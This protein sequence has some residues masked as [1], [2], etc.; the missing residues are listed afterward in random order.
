MGARNKVVW[1]NGL[2]VKPQHFQ[3]QTRYFEH[4]L[5]RLVAGNEPHFYG[6]SSLA[7]NEDLLWLGKI[8]LR[9]ASGVMPDGTVF[10]FP[11]DD[12][13]PEVLDISDGFTANELVYLC[14]PLTI[15][16][17]LEVQPA[18]E[19]PSRASAR[20]EVAEHL[21]R[22]NSVQAGE[23]AALKVARMR[24][25]LALG[26]RD[27]SAY[28]KI[29]VAR[30]VEKDDKGTIR[31]DDRFVPTMLSL[32]AAPHLRRILSDLADGVEGR[33]RSIAGRIGKPDQSG[34]AAVSDFLLL[35][36][37]NRIGALLR[38]YA[39]Q[40]TLHPRG[41]FELLIQMIGELSTFMTEERLCPEL[42]AYNHDRPDLCW[43]VVVDLLRR[44][45]TQTLDSSADWIPLEPKKHGYVL[46][47][48]ADRD[49]IR[50]AEFVLA[51]KASVPQERLQREFTAQAKVASIATI[52]ELVA[53]Q[54]P[55]IPLRLMPVAP[56]QLP[57]HAGYS[58]FALDRST[59]AWRQMADATGFAFHVAGEFPALEMQFW[60]I[61]G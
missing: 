58:Y 2:F 22:D 37:M 15:E 21:A 57:Y 46:A 40:T 13:A 32:S 19:G 31:L 41:V 45:I 9:Q 36:V 5:T 17:G 60:A 25:V 35:Q 51:V 52:R 27:L 38:H 6:F 18:A 14:L 3:Q 56:R 39:R 43:P 54:L 47:P 7:L 20:Y 33:A 30:I 55:G 1:S 29:A 48:I 12:L 16:G 24:P 42:P 44:L 8:E 49:L 4:V 26:S 34:V 11:I 28:V 10:D 23:L 61:K 53:K 50:G 59:P